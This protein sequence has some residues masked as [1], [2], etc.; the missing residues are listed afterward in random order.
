MENTRSQCYAMRVILESSLSMSQIITETRTWTQNITPSQQSTSPRVLHRSS[1]QGM[2]SPKDCNLYYHQI[3]FV[4]KLRYGWGQQIPEAVFC[5]E[6]E[7]WQAW[8]RC[9]QART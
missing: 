7:V 1:A 9:I 3:Q 5:I 4:S 2:H 8:E 6:N